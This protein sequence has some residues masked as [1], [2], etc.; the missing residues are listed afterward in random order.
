MSLQDAADHWLVTL[1]LASG[2]AFTP[3][4]EAVRQALQRRCATLDC[5]PPSIEV[6]QGQ[7]APRDPRGKLRRVERRPF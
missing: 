2:E 5:A 6:R 3:V 1:E 4:E 7:P